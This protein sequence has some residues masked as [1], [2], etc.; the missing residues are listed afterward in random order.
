MATVATW[1][2]SWLT[3][4]LTSWTATPTVDPALAAR[5]S[6]LYTNFIARYI[7]TD[8]DLLVDDIR[9]VPMS[10]DYVFDADH[11]HLSE[12]SADVVGDS[13]AVGPTNLFV[14]SDEF[15]WLNGVFEW[16]NLTAEIEGFLLYVNTGVASTSELISFHKED[17]KGITKTLTGGDI[18]WTPS[19]RGFFDV[20]PED[21]FIGRV[22]SFGHFRVTSRRDNHHIRKS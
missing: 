21:V 3:S 6:R 14:N 12:V 15:K 8:I 11:V 4:W 13:I 17:F 9:V 1:G 2:T 16:T 5:D 20:I 10:P 7:S 19:T 22:T 18:R